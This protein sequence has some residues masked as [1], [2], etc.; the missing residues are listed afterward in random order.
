MPQ[1]SAIRAPDHLISTNT[2]G[3]RHLVG[4]SAIPALPTGLQLHRTAAASSNPVKRKRLRYVRHAG[5]WL[6]LR[7]AVQPWRLLLESLSTGNLK[8]QVW[9]GVK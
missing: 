6:R 5:S 7:H 4:I 1:T 8:P 3:H 9:Q 2:V